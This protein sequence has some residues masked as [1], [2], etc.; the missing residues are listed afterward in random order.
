MLLQGAQIGTLEGQLQQGIVE[1]NMETSIVS[2]LGYIG[3]M[4]KK[5]L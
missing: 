1:K 3:I 4:E 5:L 2:I